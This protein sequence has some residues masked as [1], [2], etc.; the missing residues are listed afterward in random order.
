MRY[1]K[2]REKLTKKLLK[3]LIKRQ[4][5]FQLGTLPANSLI[6]SLLLTFAVIDFILDSSNTTFDYKLFPLIPSSRFQTYSEKTE[7]NII[8]LLQHQ[9]HTSHK[10][11]KAFSIFQQAWVRAGLEEPLKLCASAI[12]KT[13]GTQKRLWEKAGPVSCPVQLISNAYRKGGLRRQNHCPVTW[14]KEKKIGKVANPLNFP[15]GS[16]FLIPDILPWGVD[17]YQLILSCSSCPCFLSPLSVMHLPGV[18]RQTNV[19]FTG[20]LNPFPRAV[21]KWLSPRVHGYRLADSSPPSAHIW[22]LFEA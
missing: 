9:S 15:E 21:L 1:S 18:I 4:T 22:G 12:V 5:Q 13:V 3:R 17:C 10:I 11:I 8:V 19:T 7:W 2:K 20:L 6:T 16:T 14:E